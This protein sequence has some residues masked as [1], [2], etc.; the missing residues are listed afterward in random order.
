MNWLRYEI[1]RRRAEAKSRLYEVL[2]RANRPLGSYEL[3][4]KA[5]VR[6]G[7]AQRELWRWLENGVVTAEWV[8]G[9]RWYVTETGVKSSGYRVY[10][11]VPPTHGGPDEDE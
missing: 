4:K 5:H 6:N 9:S 10:T 11:L 2:E 1:Q 7:F 3:A 8:G